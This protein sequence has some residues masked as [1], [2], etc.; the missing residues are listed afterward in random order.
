MLV[1]ISPAGSLWAIFQQIILGSPF[2]NNPTNDLYLIILA[3]IFV[4]GLPM[5]MYATDLDTE[6]I[7]SGILIRFWPFHRK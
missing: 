3:L 1:L 6:V 2:G 4:V 7:E 5:F